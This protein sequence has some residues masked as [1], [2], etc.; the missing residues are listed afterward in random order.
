[1]LHRR[2]SQAGIPGI[3][4]EA[5]ISRE[6]ELPANYKGRRQRAVDFVPAE[7]RLDFAR[8]LACHLEQREI[9][10]IVRTP[11]QLKCRTQDGS[12]KDR[13]HATQEM[14]RVAGF[15]LRARWLTPGCV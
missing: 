8:V 4:S 10:A 14:A 12:A 6:Q 11:M 15:V 1:M 9:G 7:W 3:I 2:H 13:R 5:D